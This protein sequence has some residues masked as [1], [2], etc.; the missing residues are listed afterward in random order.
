MNEREAKYW[1]LRKWRRARDVGTAFNI[2]FHIPELKR[3]EGSGC[4]YCM[5]YFK[6]GNSCIGC[7]VRVDDMTCWHLGHPFQIPECRENYFPL[8]IDLIA[9]IEVPPS[10]EEEFFRE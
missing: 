4:S 8:M 10:T 5:V 1:A 7:P 3:F 9:S 2:E 6:R